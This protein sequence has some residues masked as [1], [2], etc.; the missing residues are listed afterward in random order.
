MLEESGKAAAA[1]AAAQERAAEGAGA[2]YLA[3]RGLTMDTAQEFGFGY[4]EVHHPYDG[5]RHPA[6]VIP[7]YRGRRGQR[8]VLRAVRYRYIAPPNKQKIISEVGSEFRGAFYGG[9]TLHVE[10][11]AALIVTEGEFNSAAAWQACRAAGLRVDVLSLGSES[12][13]LTEKMILF[14]GSYETCVF[15]MD[16]A[17]LAERNAS[18]VPGALGVTGPN[19]LDANELLRRGGLAEYVAGVVD[20]ARRE[21]ERSLARH[22]Q[23]L[24]D[25]QERRCRR[26]GIEATGEQVEEARMLLMR[27]APW[28]RDDRA[29]WLRV[30]FALTGLGDAGLA[31]WDAWSR[32]SPKYREGECERAWSK[33]STEGVGFG[34]LVYMANQ[35]DPS[36]AVRQRRRTASIARFFMVN[37]EATA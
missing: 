30:G 20:Y 7:W 12:A 3:Q 37:R 5:A 11:A 27:L 14:A 8:G 19:G 10:R 13:T 16:K 24:Q 22:R 4:A 1:V 33:F 25:E 32:P 36:G 29:E 6:I 21:K 34:T 35:D 2:D 31:L 9:H 23:Q 28:R 18:F 26:A 17:A 15:W